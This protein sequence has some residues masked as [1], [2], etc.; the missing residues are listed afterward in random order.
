MFQVFLSSVQ[1]FET[2]TD[3]LVASSTASSS[4]RVLT[5]D[6]NAPVVAETSVQP[7][8]LHS[9]NVFTQALVK[10][11]SIL[12]AGLAIFDI[13]LTIQHVRWDLELQR[14][15]NYCHNLIDL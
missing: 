12:V 6:T 1:R 7:H 11:I 8:L 15:S 4:L 10:E 3:P 5:T 9:L 2:S 14:I 13:P